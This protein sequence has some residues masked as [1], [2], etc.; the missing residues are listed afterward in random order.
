M[1]RNTQE[2]I[3]ALLENYNQ[4]STEISLMRFEL[5]H[6]TAVSPEDIIEILTF[7]R[8][9]NIAHQNFPHDVEG[10]AACF[11]DISEKINNEVSN[12]IADRYLSLL[13]ER[14]RL[15]HYI[16]LLTP[17]QQTVLKEH[18]FNQRSW[19]EISNDMGI[20]R[21]TVYKIRGDAIAELSRLYTF[22]ENMFQHKE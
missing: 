7:A 3:L 17:R 19:T 22:A 16:G 2:Y 4:T 11:R 21:R 1:E 9:E 15:L 8:K 5:Q 18:Y 14:Q 13:R 20:T 12:E 6:R 10:I